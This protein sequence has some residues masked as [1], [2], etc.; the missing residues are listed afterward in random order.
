MPASGRLASGAV[1]AFEGLVIDERSAQARVRRAHARALCA[2]HF[3][4]DPFLPGAYLAGL[5]AELGGRLF[6][7]RPLARVVRCAFR[8]PVTPEGEI[9][10]RARR[11]PG[12]RVE[13]EV[14]AAGACAAR[15]T[16]V[17][18]RRA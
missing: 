1:R 10:V 13:A 8:R 14:H 12:G 11:A 17:F 3:P 2:G 4:G 6:R 16:L 18:G 7:G 5:M 15:A 9:V